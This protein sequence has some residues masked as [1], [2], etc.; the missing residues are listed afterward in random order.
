MSDRTFVLLALL[1]VALLLLVTR[2][3]IGAIRRTLQQERDEEDARRVKRNHP[4]YKEY[5]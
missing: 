2:M 1:G 5:R 4:E 3:L